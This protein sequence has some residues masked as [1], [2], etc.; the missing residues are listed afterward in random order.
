MWW[1]FGPPHLTLK[2]S[3]KKQNKTQKNNKKN[4]KKTKKEKVKNTKIPKK[5]LFS[6]QSKFSFFW[7]GYPKIAFFDTLA[8]K[9]APKNT[10]KLWVSAYFF[11]KKL[12]VP[13]RP[14]WT[15]KPKIQKFQLSFF[16]CLFLFQKQKNTKIC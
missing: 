15:K 5:E 4:K 1:P 6:Y 3:P 8:Q 13:K 14:F 12:C 16:F 10:I 2:P 11:W 9:R 7:T